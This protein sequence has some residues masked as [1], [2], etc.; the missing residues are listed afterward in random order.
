MFGHF[1]LVY[2]KVI[3]RHMTNTEIHI[4]R[5]AVIAVLIFWGILLEFFTEH[6]GE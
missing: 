3:I 4:V 5:W 2:N 6:K 1:P